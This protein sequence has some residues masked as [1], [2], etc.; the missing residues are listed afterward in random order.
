LVILSW[1]LPNDGE[2]MSFDFTDKS[3]LVTGAAHGFGRAIALAFVARGARV[4]ACDVNGDG[5]AE[6]MRLANRESGGMITRGHLET[7]TVDVTDR[8][9]VA[10]LVAEAEEGATR[11]LEGTGAIDILVNNA[12]GVLGQVGRPLE[13]VTAEEWRTIFAVNVDAAFALAQLAAP[14]MKRSRSGRIV[15]ISSGA[16]LGVSLTGIQAYAAAKAA[17]IGLTR[18]LAHELGAWGITVNNVAPGFVRSNPTTE[19]QWQS[20]GDKG[21]RELVERIALKRLGTPEDIANA[22]LFFASPY[23]GWVT[24]QV[25][26]V[27]GG[28]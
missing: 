3:V 27:D 7:R 2:R 26:S 6:T 17:Q 11:A 23:A 24:G 4:W 22:V 8:E 9:A 13:Q 1:G 15:N 16:G 18:Q 19:R 14:G 21:Q 5:L 10:A 12:G 28:K 25:L 20:Y